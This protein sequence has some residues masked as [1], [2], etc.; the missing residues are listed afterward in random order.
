MKLKTLEDFDWMD[1]APTDYDSSV[2]CDEEHIKEELK[3]EAIKWIKELEVYDSYCLT[4]MKELDYS[5]KCYKEGHIRLI[6]VDE[7]GS[8]AYEVGGAVKILKHIF[9]ITEEDLK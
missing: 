1:Y 9:N 5:A 2:L 3:R 4:C 6:Y 8:S 7:M